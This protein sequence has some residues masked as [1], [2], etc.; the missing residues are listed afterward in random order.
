ML[1]GAQFKIGQFLKHCY[2]TAK[3]LIGRLQRCV[4]RR[5]NGN[6]VGFSGIIL[7]IVKNYPMKHNS[8]F[9]G[10]WQNRKISQFTRYWYV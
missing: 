4:I 6:F 3:A 7:K 8:H 10:K 9:S 5:L 2:S 1:H